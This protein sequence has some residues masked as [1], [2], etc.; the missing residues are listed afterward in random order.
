VPTDVRTVLVTAPDDATA[1][2]LAETVVGE[3]LAACANVVPGVLSIYR[4]QGE[5]RRDPEVLL[6]I[7]TTAVRAEALRARVVELHPYELPEVLVLAVD[8]GHLPYLRW[9][10]AEVEGGA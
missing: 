10:D 9:V 6:V 1:R 8:A 2:A 3:R 5:V 4:W 7:K